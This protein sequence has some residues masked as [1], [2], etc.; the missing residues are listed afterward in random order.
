MDALNTLISAYQT[1]TSST[2]KQRNNKEKKEVVNKSYITI[3]SVDEFK[4]S[5]NYLVKKIYLDPNIN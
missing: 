2:S 1:D 3:H 5:K 4:N